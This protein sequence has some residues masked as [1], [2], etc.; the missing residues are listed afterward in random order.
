NKVSFS[1]LRGFLDCPQCWY[2]SRIL[3]EPGR[4]GISLPIGNAVHEGI[5]EARRLAAGF[6]LEGDPLQKAAD[7]FEY[8]IGR[9]EPALLDYQVSAPTH[10]AG[11]DL[12]VALVLRGVEVL[13]PEENKRGIV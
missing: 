11:K 1:S 12:V 8:E 4:I 3:E 5:A 10:D 6:Q 13:L 2:R 7:H 9:I